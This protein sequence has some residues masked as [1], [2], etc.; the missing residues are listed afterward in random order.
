[1]T[2]QEM[3]DVIAAYRDGKQIERRPVG[4]V[5]SD[6][7]IPVQTP[8]W[9]FVINDYRVK[10]VAAMWQYYYTNDN[11]TT[12]SAYD[13]NCKC[14]WDEGTGPCGAAKYGHR[15][16]GLTW[17][18]ANLPVTLRP[19]WPAICRSRSRT[20]FYVSDT[21]YADESVARDDTG[22]GDAFV[23]LATEYP[24]VMLP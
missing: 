7:W 13:E 4:N 19:H 2:P 8:E 14:W 11:C 23:R 15:N 16:M 5:R 12:K 1:M 18:P 22:C 9:N 6:A 20:S 17:R 21:V 24:P 10:P 3:I